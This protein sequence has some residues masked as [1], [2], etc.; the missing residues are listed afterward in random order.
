M[1]IDWRPGHA[2]LRVTAPD[3]AV[4]GDRAFTR[5]VP[6]PGGDAR[7]RLNLWLFRG[8]APL[9]GR[10]VEVVLRDFSFVPLADD[11]VR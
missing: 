11:P 9:N 8:K 5:G 6:T 1:T 7:L 4:L 3:G 2:R 10:P